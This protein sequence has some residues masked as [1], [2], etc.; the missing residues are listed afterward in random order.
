M[1]LPLV[2]LLKMTEINVRDGKMAQKE[3]EK[4]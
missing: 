1:T 4:K 3:T 2:N